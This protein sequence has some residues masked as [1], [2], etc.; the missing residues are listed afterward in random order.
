M[1]T[2]VLPTIDSKASLRP[3]GTV[4]D[5]EKHSTNGAIAS[6]LVA[7][8]L[9]YTVFAMVQG[10]I[11]FSLNR[12]VGAFIILV[13]LCDFLKHLTGPKVIAAC[14]ICISAVLCLGVFSTD[15]SRD[16][17]F[18]IYLSCTLL[19]LGYIARITT[20]QDIRLALRR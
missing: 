10:L 19:F 18:F 17:E 13:L 3:F 14:V 16:F 9:A 15:R 5:A 4:I 11:S 12:L 1:M 6:L 20:V 7:L 8:V 2:S